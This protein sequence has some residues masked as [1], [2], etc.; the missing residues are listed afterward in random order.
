MAKM[1]QPG[2]TYGEKGESGE[3]I[4]GKTKASDGSGERSVKM[5]GGIGMGAKDKVG[6]MEH[7]VGRTG[8]GQHDGRTGE[9][10][11]HQGESVVYEHKRYEHD[12]DDY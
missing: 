6:A 5:V 3:A 1:S 2:T 4:P 7:G 11:G 10:K 9:F 8:F 12:Q